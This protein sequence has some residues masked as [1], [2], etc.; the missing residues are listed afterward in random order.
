M[1]DLFNEAADPGTDADATPADDDI[2]DLEIDIEDDSESEEEPKP[3]GDKPEDKTA[4]EKQPDPDSEDEQ[5]PDAEAKKP[6]SA[7]VKPETFELKHLGEVKQVG[8]D[9]VIALAQKG[10]DYDH[11]KSKLE[12]LEKG[13]VSTTDKCRNFVESLAKDA[14]KS[15]DDVIMETR[16]E[17]LVAK[18][19]S[20]ESAK[21][22]AALIAE[23]EAFAAEKAEADKIKAEKAK[24]EEETAAAAKK[25][26]EDLAALFAL[27][28]EV[29]SKDIPKSVWDKVN[30]GVPIA[31]AYEKHL[32]DLLTAE[33]K[34][35]KQNKENKERSTGSAD[36]SG[37]KKEKYD[38]FMEALSAD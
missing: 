15:I 24:A 26:G 21:E 2:G 17:L 32:N 22:K 31:T 23:R 28:P 29:K 34:A 16:I 25:R 10:M 35:L 33:N 9:E 19:M 4:E 14:G 7:E 27:H 3:G 6:D 30:A 5:K 37:S 13:E 36:S 20:P 12:S 18:G 8:K 1:E 11:V 38:P